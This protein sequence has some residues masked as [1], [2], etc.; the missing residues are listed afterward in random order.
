[1]TRE[2]S[3]SVRDHRRVAHFV[4]QAAGIQLP[5][6]KRSL[7]ETRLRRRLKATGYADFSSYLD[8][9]LDEAQQTREQVQLIDA[10]TTNK[11]DFFREPPHFAFLESHI[12]DHL[13]LRRTIGWERPLSVWSAACSTGEEPYTLALVLSDLQENLPGFCF[14]IQATDIAPSVLEVARKGVYT[15]SQVEPVPKALRYRYLLRSRDPRQG[16]VKM[17]PE[18]RRVVRFSEFNLIHGNYPDKPV[19]DV[20][21]CRNV[22]IYFNNEDRL[23]IIDRLRQTLYPG[24]LLIVGH[25]ENIGDQRSY[26][27][28]LRPTIYRRLR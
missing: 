23:K 9:A 8:F 27:E 12:R 14:Q 4:Q 28:T 5:E 13:A 26:F 3:L 16:L 10:I 22:M 2:I 25:S 24:G 6:R 20:I 7:I 15:T 17:G 11:T 1:M 18:L 19:H 21:F